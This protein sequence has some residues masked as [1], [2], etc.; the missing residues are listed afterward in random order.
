MKT[1]PTKRFA[2]TNKNYVIMIIFLSDWNMPTRVM[3]LSTLFDI[4]YDGF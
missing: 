1:L 4:A 2:E 3:V